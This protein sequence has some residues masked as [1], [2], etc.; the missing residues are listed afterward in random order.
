MFSLSFCSAACNVMLYWTILIKKR[1]FR[2]MLDDYTSDYYELLNKAD[3]P[4]MKILAL[5]YL[6]IEVYKCVNGLSPEYLNDLFTIKKCKYDLS[7]D[8]LINRS[9]VLTTNHGLKSFKGYGAKIWN[10]LPE[11]CKGAISLVEFKVFI[12]FWNGPKCSCSVCLHFTWNILY[13]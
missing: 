6:A 3:V 11:S 9:K 12:K 2:F 1:V 4:V 10:I 8:S 7:D 13:L 5:R